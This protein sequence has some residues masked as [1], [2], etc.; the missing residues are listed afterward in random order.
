MLKK[1]SL[2]FIFFDLHQESCDHGVGAHTK[3]DSTGRP[4]CRMGLPLG[5]DEAH[6]EGKSLVIWGPLPKAEL[7]RGYRRAAWRYAPKDPFRG[8]PTRTCRPLSSRPKRPIPCTPASMP[9]AHHPHD[10]WAARKPFHQRGN[11]ST[12]TIPWFVSAY[13]KTINDCHYRTYDAGRSGA[14]TAPKAKRIVLWRAC[15]ALRGLVGPF[16]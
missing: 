7:C 10:A 6:S 14:E 8:T 5:S 11:R 13:P 9:V 16:S 3:A 4:V 1:V 12:S 2:L 15:C